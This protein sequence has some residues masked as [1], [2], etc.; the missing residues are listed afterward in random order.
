LKL[1]D[2]TGRERP[3]SIRLVNDYEPSQ[4]DWGEFQTHRKLLGLLTVSHITS[5]TELNEICRQHESLKVY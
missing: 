3:V 5:Q 1:S 2:S 4:N